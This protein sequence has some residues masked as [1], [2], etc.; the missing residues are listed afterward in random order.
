MEVGTRPDLPEHGDP[1]WEAFIAGDWERSLVLNDEERDG[2]RAE[3]KSLREQGVEIRRLRIVEK[4]VTPY[5][6]WEMQYF[7]ILAE[8]GFSLR[9]LEADSIADYERS[10]PLPDLNLL[11]ERVLYHIVQEPDG[12]P[13]GARRIDDPDSIIGV[14]R[15]M[16][17]LFGRAEPVLDYFHREIAPLPAPTVAP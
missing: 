14:R 3:A 7:R 17:S 1:S 2:A 16:E 10:G 13:A 12:T 4:P 9:V 5:V 11:G 6:Q 15:A 8:E